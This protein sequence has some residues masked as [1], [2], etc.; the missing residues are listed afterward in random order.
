MNQ[1]RI[2]TRK[3]KAPEQPAE[4]PKRTKKLLPVYVG[5]A[6]LI[7]IG[8]IALFKSSNGAR[9][10]ASLQAPALQPGGAASAPAEP[11]IINGKKQLTF[12][13]LP[14]TAENDLSVLY[15]GSVYFNAG[16]TYEW[17]VNGAVVT[18]E[19]SPVLKR[20][21]FKKGDSVRVRLLLNAS[22]ETALAG[23][24]IVEN[25]PPRILSASIEPVPAT[26]RDRLIPK[27]L[28]SDADG[29]TVTYSYRWMREDGSVA[30]TEESIPGSLFSKNEKIILEVTPSDGT[31]QGAP[32]KSAL[33]LAN[34]LPRITSI[35]GSY[36]GKEYTYQ[37]TAE[38]PDKDPIT[39]SLLKAPAGMTID[40]ASGLV[41]WAFTEKDAGIYPIEIQ[42]SDPDG[43]GDIQSFQLPLSFTAT[44][45]LSVTPNEIRAEK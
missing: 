28:A 7:L 4:A 43:A 20:G 33:T 14:L 8:A 6:L 9:D 11:A 35:P 19:Q 3:K 22:H 26:R 31:T 36:A 39:Y 32:F 12:A 15:G 34:A 41:R 10:A 30:G 27:I 21:A 17:E 23:P 16:D 13:S 1:V 44:P 5:G 37:V 45:A 40:P 42:V 29:D 2:K 18:G 38:D 24:A 25:S